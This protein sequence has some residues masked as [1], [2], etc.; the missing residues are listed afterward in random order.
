MSV[1]Q[2]KS[3]PLFLTC[4]V[5]MDKIL[6]KNFYIV[7]Q[8]L[9]VLLVKFCK[10][11]SLE[12]Y[13]LLLLLAFTLVHIIFHK[14]SEFHSTLFE[15]KIFVTNFPF[16]IDSLNSLSDPHLHPLNSQ[17]PLSVTRFFLSMVHNLLQFFKIVMLWWC[18]GRT[19][20][21]EQN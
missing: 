2:K 9:K 16:L 8:L 12:F 11:Q 7:F 14:F 17:N 5:K 10:I 21:A 3:H 4:H 19:R 6:T 20:T 13:F 15:K 1:K 18:F